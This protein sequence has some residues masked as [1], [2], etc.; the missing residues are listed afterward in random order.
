MQRTG[1]RRAAGHDSA[2]SRLILRPGHLTS[3]KFKPHICGFHQRCPL[4]LAGVKAINL[5]VNAA[6]DLALVDA[7]MDGDVPAILKALRDGA[8]IEKRDQ[9]GFTALLRASAKGQLRCPLIQMYAGM[10]FQPAHTQH[11]Q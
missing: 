1:C 7:T 9:Y 2:P 3:R 4:A 10:G 8:D 6:A 5:K 11:T